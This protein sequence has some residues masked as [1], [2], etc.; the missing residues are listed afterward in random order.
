MLTW[1]PDVGVLARIQLL[2]VISCWYKA[3]EELEKDHRIAKTSPL[4]SLLAQVFP[5]VQVTDLCFSDFVVAA[6]CGNYS[7]EA[8][9][10]AR[11]SGN[12]ALSAP[13]LPAGLLALMRRVVNYH[14]SWVGQQQ[15][16][17]LMHLVFQVSQL[18]EV[19][20]QVV[21]PQEVMPPIR[22][23]R[24]RGQFQDESGDQNEDQR[25]FPSHGH[26]RREEDE[27][28]NLA[29]RVVTDLCCS[30]FVVAAVCGNYSSE[31]GIPGFDSAGGAPGGGKSVPVIY[32]I[33]MHWYHRGWDVPGDAWVYI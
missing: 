26:G 14:S 3:L 21:V 6:V 13:H 19:M 7:S 23:G 1:I 10:D 25:S 4:C 28:D 15:V 9:E 22:R 31:A 5:A 30:D 18:V 32:S 8:G 33:Y 29:N 11:T 2:R 16:E 24:G 20:I 17:L 27:V 12:T